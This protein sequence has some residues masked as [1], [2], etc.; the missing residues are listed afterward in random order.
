MQ[1]TTRKQTHV[2]TPILL[3][4]QPPERRRQYIKDDSQRIDLAPENVNSVFKENRARP[5]TSGECYKTRVVGL[6]EGEGRWSQMIEYFAE[7]IVVPELPAALRKHDGVSLPRIQ[8][9][10]PNSS[11]WHTELKK[12]QE[13]A[14][15]RRNY[16]DR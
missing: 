7:Y 2:D 1:Q 15:I 3:I 14:E 4:L 16:R 12:L 13:Q 5:G 10:L 9:L 8:V 11:G 6:I